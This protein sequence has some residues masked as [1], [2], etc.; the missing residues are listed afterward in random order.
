MNSTQVIFFLLIVTASFLMTINK[1]QY[2]I[3]EWES[4]FREAGEPYAARG[5]LR[6]VAQQAWGW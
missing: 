1:S 2:K 6:R 3:T 5:Q 4:E